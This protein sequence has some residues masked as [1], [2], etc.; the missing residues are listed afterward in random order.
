MGVTLIALIALVG[1]RAPGFDPL[2]LNG[3]TRVPPPPTGTIGD[4]SNGY[5]EPAPR[6]S[7]N[8]GAASWPETNYAPAQESGMAS[9]VSPPVALRN[10]LPSFASNDRAADTK[11]SLQPNSVLNWLDPAPRQ[12]PYGAPSYEPASSY[13]L[14]TSNGYVADNG[15]A[16]APRL[17]PAPGATQPL[18][19]APPRIRGFSSAGRQDLYIPP[20]LAQFR[21]DG[22]RQAS[23]NSQWQ[24]RY[25][26]MR[27]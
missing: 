2:G 7:L 22:V 27:R 25:D 18:V 16:Y 9:R 6:P 20:E 10:D 15:R 11:P 23:V 12:S 3:P 1:C 5:Y 14:S 26:D 13:G 4:R 17:L 24:P 8:Q 19:S 21:S